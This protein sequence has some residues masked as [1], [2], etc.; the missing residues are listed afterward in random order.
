[1]TCALQPIINLLCSP[2]AH[3]FSSPAPW[4]E[5][6]ILLTEMSSKSPGF[7]KWQLKHLYTYK[8]AVLYRPSLHAIMPWSAVKCGDICIFLVHCFSPKF[9]ISL[10]AL[11]AV[12]IVSEGT[13]E[14]NINA[15]KW[16]PRESLNCQKH[17]NF[18]VWHAENSALVHVHVHPTLQLFQCSPRPHSHQ[19]N[20]W[21]CKSHSLQGQSPQIP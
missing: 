3:S 11:K 19:P 4:T 5:Y 17:T 6:S 9:F 20:H 10:N 8:N 16:W 14:S 21:C 12:F 1:M 18:P 2:F 15:E 13:A 7:I